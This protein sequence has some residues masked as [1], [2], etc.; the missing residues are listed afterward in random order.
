MLDCKLQPWG[1]TVVDGS[2][3]PLVVEGDFQG[4]RTV[5]LAFDIYQ[6]DFPLRAAF[7]IFMANVINH[8][9][10]ASGDAAGRSAA[11]GERVNL[12][13]PLDAARVQTT[14]PDGAGSTLTLGTRDYTLSQTMQTGVYELAYENEGGEVIARDQLP[15]SLLSEDESTITPAATLRVQGL[16]EAIASSGGQPK[17]IAATREVRVNREFYTWLILLVLLIMGVEW[18]LYHTRAL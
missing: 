10:Q 8:L 12:V 1:R 15:V 3:G 16:T 13:A 17:E 4:Q 2:E 14:A 7:P 6:S 18:Y 5:Y 11:A 9:G